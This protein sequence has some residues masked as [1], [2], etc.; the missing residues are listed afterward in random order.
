MLLEYQTTIHLAALAGGF[1]IIPGRL[2]QLYERIGIR[3][4]M[5]RSENVA[6]AMA[7]LFYPVILSPAPPARAGDRQA[8]LSGLA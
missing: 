3:N 4:A 7:S 2:I 1:S 6:I 8:W 5:S